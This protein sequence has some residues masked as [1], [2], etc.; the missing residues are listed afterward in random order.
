MLENYWYIA[1]RGKALKNKPVPFTLFNRHMVLF[2]DRNNQPAALEDRCQHRNARLSCGSIVEGTVRCP[3]H[4]WRYDQ[5]GKLA[6]IPYS[7]TDPADDHSPVPSFPC[8]EQNGYIWVSPGQPAASKPYPFPHLDEP[9]WVSFRMNTLFDGPVESCLENFLD[10]PHA[11]HVHRHWFRTPT[12]KSV[13]ATIRTLDDGAIVEYFSEPREKSVVWLLLSPGKEQMKHTDR[14]I[15]PAT[16]RV[17]YKFTND[18]EYIITSSCT[19]IDEASTRVHTV[20][21]FRFGKIAPLVRLFFEPLSRL[22]IKQ[23]VRI[24]RQQQANIRRFGKA[25]FT[26]IEQ[27]VLFKPILA[28][29]KALRDGTPPPKA[30]EESHIN[31]RL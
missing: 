26:V 29:R 8:C 20:I 27:D 31:M 5:S 23:D 19:P 7:D 28:W 21:S 9:G 24:I 6:E 2:R 15:A 4:G 16:S 18:R 10:C 14:F 1:C 12:S 30:G 3:Y 25:D 17:D 11:T 22:I 13:K